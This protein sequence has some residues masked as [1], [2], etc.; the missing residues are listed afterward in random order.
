MIVPNW[1]GLQLHIGKHAA[2]MNNPM[3]FFVTINIRAQSWQ[4]FWNSGNSFGE[5]TAMF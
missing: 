1:S 5:Y 4:T 2:N 3:I